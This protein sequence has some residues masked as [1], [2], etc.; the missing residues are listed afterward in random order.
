MSME[1]GSFGWTLPVGPPGGEGHPA[2]GGQADPGMEGFLQE[3]QRRAGV[4]GREEA[5]RTVRGTLQSLRNVL[6]AD[7]LERLRGILPPALAGWLARDRPVA[8]GLVDQEVFVGPVV[9]ALSTEGLYD[10]SLGGL[11][12]Y[13]V[14]TGEE[15]TRRI[16]AVFSVLK[17]WMDD[18]TIRAV[19]RCLPGD[20]AHWFWGA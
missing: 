15:A 12:L 4:P 14:F 18:A 1:W 11:D 7:L 17:E 8:D 20:V 9:Q 16:Q 13:S 5:L 10:Q 2:G 6:P 3:V 19:A